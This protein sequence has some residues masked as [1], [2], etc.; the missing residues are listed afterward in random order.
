MTHEELAKRMREE[1]EQVD[2]LAR[3]LREWTAVIP[4]VN[5]PRWIEGARQRFDHFRS[6]LSRHFTLE[7]QEGYMKAVVDRRPMLAAEVDRLCH[8]HV[9][10][11]RIMDA[12]YKAVHELKPTDRLLI[13]DVCHR[14]GDLLTYVEHH[15]ADE[16]MLISFVF[17]QD[18]PPRE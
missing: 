5:F 9:E 14:V 7:E 10:L 4:K 6:H 3:G 12:L 1:H 18:V 16:N 2:V 15:E 17:T 13:R 8:E 11:N